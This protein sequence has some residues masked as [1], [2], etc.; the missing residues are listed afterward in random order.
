MTNGRQLC[1]L[2]EDGVKHKAKSELIQKH[3]GAALTTLE[4]NDISNRIEGE[5]IQKLISTFKQ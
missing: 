5:N 4:T 1:Q 2:T 3:N